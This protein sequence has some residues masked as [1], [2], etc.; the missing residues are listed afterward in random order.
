MSKMR[1]RRTDP[2][3]ERFWRDLVHGQQRSG[4]SVREYCRQAGVK[5]SSFY[6][7]RRELARRSGAPNATRSQPARGRKAARSQPVR[8][9]KAARSSA[10]DRSERTGESSRRRKPRR[11]WPVAATSPDS[12]F[13]RNEA[14]PFVPIQASPFVPIHLSAG[15]SAADAAVVEIHL[16]DGRMVR[17]GPGF[18][19]QTL[20][21]VLSALEGR[22]C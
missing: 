10:A 7:W 13:L 4:Q 2:E 11:N 5:E 19:R 17:V 21:E 15:S 20:A 6:W 9:R 14:S 18:D 12:R 22:T 1:L 8:G 16:G 3:K